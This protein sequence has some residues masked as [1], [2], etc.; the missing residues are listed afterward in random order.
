MPPQPRSGL[1]SRDMG[2][3]LRVRCS[4][5]ASSF[6]TWIRGKSLGDIGEAFNAAFQP[7][8][9][10]NDA[11]RRA[12]LLEMRSVYCRKM[13][14]NCIALRPAAFCRLRDPTYLPSRAEVIEAFRLQEKMGAALSPID[15]DLEL[16]DRI[17]NTPA[18]ARSF[19]ENYINEFGPVAFS[20][21]F[22]FCEE[23]GMFEVLTREYVHALAEYI[24]ERHEALPADARHRP[25]VELAA[26]S[27]RLS[28]F[29]QK[30][31]S[32]F[33]LVATDDGSWGLPEPFTV[34]RLPHEAALQVFDPAISLCS[35]MPENS[36]F[37]AEWRHRGS[38]S[39]YVLIGPADSGLSGLPW[40]T[41]GYSP[42]DG[43]PAEL[44]E[45]IS[46]L[47]PTDPKSRTLRSFRVGLAATQRGELAPFC[48][49]GFERHAVGASRLQ[50]C[51]TDSHSNSHRSQT[52]SFRR[53]QRASAAQAQ[54]QLSTT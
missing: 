9:F 15:A 28:H 35:W 16:M 19:E 31:K 36:D 5:A 37:T 8:A 25:V 30:E 20:P 14:H 23:Q 40:E 53:T 29:L 45:A 26:G 47:R 11:I 50:L 6:D 48:A 1:G 44:D 10:A 27:G 12:S 3:S 17:A 52:V 24:S 18:A 4:S 46:S 33:S 32:S 39:E 7:G 2:R 51:R 34:T 54:P 41:W 21:L 42:H 22:A 43:E 38:M 13:L 49:E